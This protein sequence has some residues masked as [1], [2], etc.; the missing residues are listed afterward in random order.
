MSSNN[1]YE[2]CDRISSCTKLFLFIDFVSKINTKYCLLE[3]CICY[4]RASEQKAKQ[5]VWISAFWSDYLVWIAVPLEHH[6]PYMQ[7]EMPCLSNKHEI[8]EKNSPEES[9]DL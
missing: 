7:P 5:I 1:F 6:L 9:K 3:Y 2:D 4:S 8:E